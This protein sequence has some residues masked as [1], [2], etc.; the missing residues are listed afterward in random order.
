VTSYTTHFAYRRVA[1]GDSII[2]HIVGIDD[3]TI[4]KAAHDVAC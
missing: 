3:L 4:A 1:N 2:D